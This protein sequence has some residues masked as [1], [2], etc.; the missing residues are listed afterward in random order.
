MKKILDYKKQS[1]YKTSNLVKFSINDFKK[2]Y[3]ASAKEYKEWLEQAQKANPDSQSIFIP[4]YQQ[5]KAFEA[6]MNPKYN[7]VLYGGSVGSAK[8]F[9]GAFFILSSA[10]QFPGTTYLIGRKTAK[11]LSDSTVLSLL[12]VIEKVLKIP[13]KD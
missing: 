10:L 3:E 5:A 13:K 1:F 6:L 12:E 8:S 4:S 2:V 11:S 7:F 9:L